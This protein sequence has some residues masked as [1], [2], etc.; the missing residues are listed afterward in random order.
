MAAITIDNLQPMVEYEELSDTELE[1]V[2]GGLFWLLFAIAAAHSVP[3]AVAAGIG[4]AAG[5]SGLGVGVNSYLNK[6]R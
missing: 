2:V 4:P 3:R 6:A 1:S 5:L